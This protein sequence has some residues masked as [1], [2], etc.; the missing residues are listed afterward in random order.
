[1]KKFKSK[2]VIILIISGVLL[3][4]SVLSLITYL[5]VRDRSQINDEEAID[6]ALEWGDLAELPKTVENIE[7]ESEGGIFT[8]TFRITFEAD[9]DEIGTWL[10][11][12]EGISDATIEKSDVTKYIISPKDANRV[13]V[14]INEANGS[15][16]IYASWS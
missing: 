11:S 5:I 15:V 3:L 14:S 13:E 7:V 8:R 1:M 12:S 4:C 2:K 10:E 6:L 9:S 16:E